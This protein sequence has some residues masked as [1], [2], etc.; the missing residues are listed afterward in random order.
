M[1]NYV[2]NV[3]SQTITLCDIRNVVLPPN[4]VVNLLQFATKVE[5]E[6]SADLALILKRDKTKETGLEARVP[7]KIQITN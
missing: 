6:A 1:D 5:I 2:R 3:T 7:M 4:Q